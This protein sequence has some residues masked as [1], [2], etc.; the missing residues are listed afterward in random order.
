MGRCGDSFSC[1]FN[2]AVLVEEDS[3]AQQFGITDKAIKI[4]D[5]LYLR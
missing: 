3:P 2:V 5:I 1:S 4:E